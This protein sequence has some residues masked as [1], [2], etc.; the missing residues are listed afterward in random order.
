MWL[1]SIFMFISLT[2]QLAFRLSHLHSLW[3]Y[4]TLSINVLHQ[5]SYYLLV[6]GIPCLTLRFYIY[7]PSRNLTVRRSLRGLQRYW[8]NTQVRNLTPQFFFC[9]TPFTPA[10]SG[11]ELV[12][13]AL[14]PVNISSLGLRNILPITT[15]KV[16]I[17]KFEHRQSG[18]EGDIS[19][20]NTLVSSDTSLA[21]CLLF[22]VGV[23][24]S[25][26]GTFHFLS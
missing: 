24:Y 22:A 19:L 16:P 9:N 4:L 18:L 1:E 12:L 25:Q 26:S 5:F 6:I 8:R 3:L 10:L 21:C 13:Q 11:S 7:A 15:A 23:L 2:H 20:Y 17:V 14:P